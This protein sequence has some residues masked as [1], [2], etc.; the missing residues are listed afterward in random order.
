[1]RQNDTHGRRARHGTPTA[2]ERGWDDSLYEGEPHGGDGSGPGPGGSGAAADV[3]AGSSGSDGARDAADADPA[4]EGA[5]PSRKR[6]KRKRRVLRWSASILALLIVGTAGAGYL[7]YRH[8]NGNLGKDQLNLGERKL[9]KS[10]PNA[11]GQTP[12]NIL[13]LGSDSRGSEE[14]IKLGG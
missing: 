5:R 10:D 13:L 6:P 7:Y 9:D 1:M 8:L 2:A 4:E 3:S 14:N 11:E 12:M